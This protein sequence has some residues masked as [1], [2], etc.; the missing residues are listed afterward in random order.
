MSLDD[1]LQ[2]LADEKRRD[3]L[4]ALENSDSDSFTYSEVIDAL[5]EGGEE[6]EDYRERLRL[7]MS[8]VHLPKMEVNGLVDYDEGSEVI[9]YES[10]EEIRELL[11]L[12]EELD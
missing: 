8:H 9:T 3:M 1:T 2:V 4:Y 10:N 5:R 6:I 11:G 12:V 7:E